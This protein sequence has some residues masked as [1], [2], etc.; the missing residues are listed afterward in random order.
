METRASYMLVGAFV[1]AFMAGLVGFAVWLTKVQLE[2]TGDLYYIYFSGSVTGLQEGSPVRYAGIPVGTVTDIR[3]AP[4]NVSLVRVTAELKDGTPIKSDTI[5]SLELQGLTGTAYVQLTGGTQGAEPL[6]AGNGEVPVIRSR[7]S[8][9]AELADVA[10]QVLNRAAELADRLSV[11]L[12]EQNQE[13]IS[14]ILANVER[15]TGDASVAAADARKAMLALEQLA[16][17]ARGYT[18]A[19]A[20]SA[21]QTLV[22]TRRT[23]AEA[24]DAANG[25]QQLARTANRAAEQ[26]NGLIGENRGPIRDFSEAGLYDLTLLVGELRDLAGTLS[27]VTTRIERDPAGF[28][29]GGARRGEE[30]K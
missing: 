1:L 28:F 21:D 15:L 8:A 14:G 9:L 2:D 18:R 3:L 16:G 19:L 26:L 27:R 12:S 13:R 25:F 20:E 22:Q 6:K 5:A 7:P 24:Q 10:P 4:E 17:D 23:L 11:L 30:V 29:L